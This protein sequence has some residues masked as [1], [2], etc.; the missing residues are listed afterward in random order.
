MT[1]KKRIFEGVRPI[2][3]GTV[4][5]E[6]AAI[7]D[8]PRQDAYGH[9]RDNYR[10]LAQMW[11]AYLGIDITPGQAVDMMMLVKMARQANTSKRD[12]L[13]DLAGYARVAE[14][15]EEPE[16][17]ASQDQVGDQV[18]TIKKPQSVA[19]ISGPYRAP[20]IHGI[21]ENIE[22]ARRVALE[23]WRKGYAVICPHA[24]TAFMDG[25]ADD[26]VWLCGDIT[27]LR[28]MRPDLGDCIV[29][30]PRWRE[31]SGAQKELAE[32]EAFGLAIVY[33]EGD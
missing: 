9:P 21:R 2:A 20:S 8:G 17:G 31:S 33:A 30:M 24:N 11:G 16:V 5:E 25:A 3:R 14:M 22:A 13:V 1:V 23:W 27:F 6:A 29:M 7:V 15:L 18:A 26:E 32:A 10:R 12:N 4:L 28:R 19:Y